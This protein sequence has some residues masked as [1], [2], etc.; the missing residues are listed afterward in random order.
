MKTERDW[1]VLDRSITLVLE[2]QNMNTIKL[3][4][5]SLPKLGTKMQNY[6]GICW[7]KTVSIK[8]SNTA[9][10]VFEQY[11]KANDQ[12]YVPDDEV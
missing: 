2:M 6:I 10:D 4:H 3:K 1:L 12:F 5:E 11:F 9:S 7:K 8:Q